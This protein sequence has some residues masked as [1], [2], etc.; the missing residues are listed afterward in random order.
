MHLNERDVWRSLSQFQQRE[1]LDHTDR[2]RMR[3]LLNRAEQFNSSAMS[4]F[5]YMVALA[6]PLGIKSTADPQLKAPGAADPFCQP[7]LTRI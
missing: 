4:N 2:M 3:E 1:P 7:L 6:R 5:Q